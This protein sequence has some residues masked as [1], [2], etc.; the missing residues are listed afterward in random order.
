MPGLKFKLEKKHSIIAVSIFAVG[1]FLLFIGIWSHVPPKQAAASGYQYYRTITVTS[2]ANVA[3]GTLTNFPMLISS[4]LASWESSSTGGGAGRIQN[5]V[6]APN[7]GQEPADLV[8]ATSSANCGTANLNFETESYVSSTG[9]L[10]DWVNV[11]TMSTGTVIYACYDNSSITTDQSHPS[12]TWNSNYAGV[13]HLISQAG[14]STPYLKDSTVNANNGLAGTKAIST[15][16]CLLS[17]GCANFT[18]SELINVGTNTSISSLS[19]PFTESAWVYTGSSTSA[20]TDILDQ[21]QV[22]QI[23]IF[24]LNSAKLAVYDTAIEV[25]YSTATPTS[26]LH[27]VVASIS[28]T[29]STATATLYLDGVAQTFSFGST[30]VSTTQATTIGNAYNGSNPFNGNIQEVRLSSVALSSQWIL[31]EYNNEKSP[32]TFYAVGNETALGGGGGAVDTW[33]ATTTSNWNT[34]ANWSLGFVPGV[35]S[36]ATFGSP[37]I[38]NCTINA[39]VNV[40]GIN[41]GAAYTGTITQNSGEVMTVGTSSWTQSGGTFTGSSA[42]DAVSYLGVRLPRP[43]AISPS[44]PRPR[45]PEAHFKTIREQ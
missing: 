1:V 20:N 7:G 34:A 42:G 35:T 40:G 27:Y 32:S 43:P 28:G 45:S 31:T 33:L 24:R 12:S 37:G 11:P 2:T 36:T 22:S 15:T 41:I 38:G 4:T 9:A 29:T 3:S 6:T 14:T 10:I 5:L 13:W 23:K 19:A 30:T 25:H 21:D 39:T 18:G 16:T 44:V 26:S 17:V 8:F